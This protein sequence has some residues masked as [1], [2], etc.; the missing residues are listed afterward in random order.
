LFIEIIELA[1]AKNLNRE[2]LTVPQVLLE[3]FE[4]REVSVDMWPSTLKGF[5]INNPVF[6]LLPLALKY[7]VFT[8]YSVIWR[9]LGGKGTGPPD[10]SGNHPTLSNIYTILTKLY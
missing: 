4:G 7:I 8:C 10:K 3:D 9:K 6:P 5:A 1:G 2:A